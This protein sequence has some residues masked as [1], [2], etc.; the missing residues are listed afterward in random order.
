MVAAGMIWK[1]KTEGSGLGIHLPIMFR[2]GDYTNP[3]DVNPTLDF[4]M[5]GASIISVGALIEGKW[6]FKKWE[7]SVK[8]GKFTKLDSSYWS[9][10]MQYGF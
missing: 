5:E 2:Q 7:M 10:G 3:S 8:F 4:T 1:P 6:N 9:I